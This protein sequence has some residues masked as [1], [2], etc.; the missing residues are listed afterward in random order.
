[1]IVLAS[2]LI[3][4][5]AAAD[6][7]RLPFQLMSSP[8]YEAFARKADRL[9]PAQHLRNLH[10]GDLGGMEEHFL[11]GL[12]ARARRRIAA[13]DAGFKDCPLAGMSCPA[14]HTLAAIV[15]TGMLDGFTRSACATA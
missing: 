12:D 2:L 5:L 8:A 14:Q 1:M 9:C 6:D 15:A 3:S 11:L 10:P 13:H 7:R 4:G